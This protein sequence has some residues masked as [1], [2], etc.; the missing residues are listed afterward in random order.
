M[1]KKTKAPKKKVAVEAPIAEAP[2]AITAP[3]KAAPTPKKKE[4]E[5]T[6]ILLFTLEGHTSYRM[7]PFKTK[8][9]LEVYMDKVK[10]KHPP[11]HNKK[12]FVV[13]RINGTITPE[14]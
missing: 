13:D 7:N 3:V 2:V 10:P 9:D 4:P 8:A 11:M 5:S 14:A 12:W 6:Y 1:E